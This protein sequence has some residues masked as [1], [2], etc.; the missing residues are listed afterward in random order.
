MKSWRDYAA[1]LFDGGLFALL[2]ILIAIVALPGCASSRT[3]GEDR[4]ATKKHKIKPRI[5]RDDDRDGV[6]EIELPMTLYR[7]ML[8]G[9]MIHISCS[10]GFTHIVQFRLYDSRLGFPVLYQRWTVDEKRTHEERLRMF[11][12]GYWLPKDPFGAPRDPW[13]TEIPN[14]E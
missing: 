8:I 12:P 11:G 14:Y 13:T 4:E 7:D 10:D 9:Q 1:S 6:V 3:H 2:V 5:A